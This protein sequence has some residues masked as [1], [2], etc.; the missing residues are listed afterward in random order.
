ME[1]L[2][3]L[4]PPNHL[5][6]PSLTYEGLNPLSLLV[7]ALSLS[8]QILSPAA[9][10][11]PTPATPAASPAVAESSPSPTPAK[12]SIFDIL[13]RVP[14]KTGLSESDIINGLK[15]A[16]TQGASSAT[17]ELGR[18]DGFLGNLRVKIPVPEKLKPVDSALRRLKQSRIADQFVESL[19]RAAERAA[20]AAL[21]ILGDAVKSMSI[22]DGK[23]ILT[24]PS[25]AA[26]Q[27]LKRS[28]HERLRLA[29]LPVVQKA[30]A[31]A[32]VSAAYKSLMGKAGPLAKLAGAEAQDLDGYVTGKALDGLYLL[33]A[34]EEKRIR[35]DP[36][37]RVSDILRK[38]FGR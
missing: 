26:T 28:S 22:S 33:V 19:N 10:A 37:A 15:E 31:E 8:I 5:R 23:G 16:L 34:D 11:S 14:M 2:E 21:S 1:G 7:T 24:G 30:T 35:E 36:K 25:D 3:S 38:V 17:R 13:R 32:G 20:P 29:F 6:R 9:S 4:L 12:R 18:P 27:Y